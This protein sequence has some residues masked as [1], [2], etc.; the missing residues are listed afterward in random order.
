MGESVALQ[1]PSGEIGGWLALPA[2]EPRAGLV[3]IQEIFGVNGH[4]RGVAD[5]FAGVGYAALAPALFDPAERGVELGY[6]AAGIARG[7]G[8]CA[9]AFI[10][11]PWLMLG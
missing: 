1:T 2:R 5:R 7:A 8:I 6:D 3:V 4:I 9:C 11:A 10:G